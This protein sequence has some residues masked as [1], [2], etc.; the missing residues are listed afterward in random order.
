MKIDRAQFGKI[1]FRSLIPKLRWVWTSISLAYAVMLPLLLLQNH[2]LS[3]IL[4]SRQPALGQ[5]VVDQL[6][7]I[8]RMFELYFGSSVVLTLIAWGLWFSEKSQ[9]ETNSVK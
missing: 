2:Q 4:L 9:M 3:T 5:P 7:A 6:E 1:T 8:A